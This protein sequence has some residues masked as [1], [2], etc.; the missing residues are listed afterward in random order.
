MV[1]DKIISAIAASILF[2]GISYAK[3]LAS[4]DD[5][6]IT[7]KDFD[8]LKQQAPDFDFNKLT[9]E[10]K[11]GLINQKVNEIL[12]EKA[13]K[14]E[15]LDQTR[16]YQE[17]LENIKKQLLLQAWQHNV[18]EQAKK[19][20]I[21]EAEVKKFYDDNPKQFIQQ[22]G[23]ARHILVKTK[24]EAEKIIAEL[25]K[26]PKSRVEQKFIELANKY[27]TDPNAKKAQNGGDLGTF[28]RNQMVP[29]FGDAV[30]ALSP[31]TYT[32]T[33]VKT[34]YGYHVV[35]LIK[36]G[37]PK[38][39]SFAEAKPTIENMFK[40]RKFQEMAQDKIQHLRSNAK[41]TINH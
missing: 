27:T 9:T 23:H 6:I 36:K 37:S 31:N 7:E 8:V 13:A 32:K 28:Q 22:E 15:K 39:I 21:P 1:Y 19:T 18:A 10:Q 20:V 2:T 38:T 26:A 11:N 41:I 40:E 24:E 25:N 30:F 17:A 33:P 14:K 3:D 29:E 4:V 16:E 12:I 5:Q 35:Y 34:Q